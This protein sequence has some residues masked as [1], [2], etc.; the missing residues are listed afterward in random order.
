VALA[1]E[2]AVAAMEHVSVDITP[3]VPRRRIG[4]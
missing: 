4:S 2:G 1:A 3:P